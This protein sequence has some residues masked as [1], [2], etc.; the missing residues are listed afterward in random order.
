MYDVN[1]IRK[2]SVT[3]AYLDV[4]FEDSKSKVIRQMDAS[5]GKL[6][7]T[8]YPPFKDR[9]MNYLLQLRLG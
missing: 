7:V 6:K 3:N 2:T 8:F 1:N 9:N 5:A 4:F